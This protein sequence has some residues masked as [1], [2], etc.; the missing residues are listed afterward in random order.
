[1]NKHWKWLPKFWVF[2]LVLILGSVAVGAQIVTKF[3][4]T[5]QV[6]VQV[7]NFRSDSLGITVRWRDGEYGPR[8][9]PANSSR[10]YM[11][12]P[13]EVPDGT[14]LKLRIE[15]ATGWSCITNQSIA[16]IGGEVITLRMHEGLPVPT[17]CRQEKY[18]DDNG[19]LGGRQAD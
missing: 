1:M 10:V 9:T 12:P 13:G 3:D 17:F 11:M 2:A 8:W 15:L 7:L 18:A 6:Y 19:D 5:V 4:P 14:L 16:G